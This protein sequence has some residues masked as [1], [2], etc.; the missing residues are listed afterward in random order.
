ML[1]SDIAEEIG[2]RGLRI[3]GLLPGRFDTD[4]VRSLDAATGDAEAVRER[5]AHQIPLGRYGDPAEF[6]AVAAFLLSPAASY[7][8]GT[9]I[10]VD[11]GLTR[12]P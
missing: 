10:T 12:L 3:V 1:V 6:G 2:P 7:V 5:Y 4:R 11:G 9:C 8:T